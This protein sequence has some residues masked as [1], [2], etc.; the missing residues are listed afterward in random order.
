MSKDNFVSEAEAMY[1]ELRSWRESHPEASFDEIAEAVREKRQELMGGLLK[2]LAEQ[3]GI[4]DY[5]ADRTCPE[6]GGVM[7]YKGERKRG[8]G[9]S[10]G[11]TAIE[12]GYHRCDQC[13]H[14]FFPSG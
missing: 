8:V 9:H 2:E 12:R 3:E 5:L 6:C 7:H 1:E 10:E 14:T 11:S 4:G 13:G